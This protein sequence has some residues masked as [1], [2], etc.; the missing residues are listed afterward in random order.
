MPGSSGPPALALSCDSSPVVSGAPPAMPWTAGPGFVWSQSRPR[1][2]P[3]E[4]FALFPRT[5]AC[6]EASRHADGRPG[7]GRK[8]AV[9]AVTGVLLQSHRSAPAAWCEDSRTRP[10]GSR[11]DPQMLHE[12]PEDVTAQQTSLILEE[13]YAGCPALM[14]V[15]PR[16]GQ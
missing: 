8:G 14:D 13:T 15:R 6:N 16:S 4:R 2:S 7:R 10:P 3:P 5:S 1:S 11:Q 9:A 12:C